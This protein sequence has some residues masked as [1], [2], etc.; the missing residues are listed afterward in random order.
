MINNSSF[1][2]NVK[3]KTVSEYAK[4]PQKAHEIDAGWDF[5][6]VRDNNFYTPIEYDS[7]RHGYQDQYIY[8]LKPNRQHVFDTGIQVAIPEG[9]CL[10]LVDRSGMGAKKVVHRTA[11]L[12][13]SSYRGNILVSLVNLSNT[14]IIIAEGDKIIQG[15]FLPVPSVKWE[16]V[17]ELSNTDRGEK[18]FGSSGT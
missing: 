3:F 9:W 1:H 6:A 4:I 10:F 12:I 2:L 8:I 13:D 16:L 14:D 11:G 15:I 17:N 18:G 7:L 5:S